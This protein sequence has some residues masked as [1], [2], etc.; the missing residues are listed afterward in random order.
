MTEEQQEERDA[1][2]AA[3]FLAIPVLVAILAGVVAW[4]LGPDAFGDEWTR[5]MNSIGAAMRTLLEKPMVVF[6][7]AVSVGMFAALVQLWLVLIAMPFW[8]FAKW[9]ASRFR[10]DPALAEERSNE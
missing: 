4:R 2:Q 8:E 10:N 9:L 7:I 3:V 6:L 1:I 5:W